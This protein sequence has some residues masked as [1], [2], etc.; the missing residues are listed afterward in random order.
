[1]RHILID[2]EFLAQRFHGQQMLTA[3][4]V[5][6]HARVKFRQLDGD[7]DWRNRI[8]THQMDFGVVNL[9]GKLDGFLH[10]L[11][12]QRI[13]IILFAG[14]IHRHDGFPAL[15]PWLIFH[16]PYRARAFAQQV[17]VG[18]SENHGFQFVML[19]RHFQQQVMPTGH[20]F[21]NNGFERSVVPDHFDINRYA[22]FQVI[23][24]LLADPRGTLA[25]H[26][27]THSGALVRR[28]KGG[29]LV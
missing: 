13:V 16:H 2:T 12:V 27:L 4:R 25:D 23:F 22:R 18:W 9:V 29:H 20:H 11:L 3:N 15:R 1:M 5:V 26:S 28:Q 8:G 17:P 7:I 14:Q 24:R 21:L 6:I 19:V 10:Q